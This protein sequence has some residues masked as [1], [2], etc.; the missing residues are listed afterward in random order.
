MKQKKKSLNYLHM[1]TGSDTLIDYTCP[2][3]LNTAPTAN[4]VTRNYPNRGFAKFSGQERILK[5]L[6]SEF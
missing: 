2:L 5:V 6:S 1:K 4:L 3:V